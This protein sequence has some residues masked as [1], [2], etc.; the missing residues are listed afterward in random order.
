VTTTTETCTT[1]TRKLCAFKWQLPC[2]AD[3][4]CGDGFVCQPS[5]SGGCGSASRGVSTGPFG[6]GGAASGGSSSSPPAVDAGAPEC[7]T[8]PSFPGWC[9]T[10]ATTCTAD[11]ECPS[12]W[13]CTAIGTPTPLTG[14]GAS[15]SVRGDA[16]AASP[17]DSVDAGGSSTKI[18]IGPFGVG[19]PTRGT[20]DVGTGGE[21]TNTG[22]QGSG[23]TTPPAS[24]GS[25]ATGGTTGGANASS[26]P[27]DGG[28]AVAP[29]RAG[30]SAFLLFGLA[31]VGLGLIR[32]RSRK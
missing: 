13:T 29:P 20:V 8:V 22:H 2:N 9:R 5:V 15:T 7:Q 1:T 26:H 31:A 3:I 21:T 30:D 18:C 14:I 28:C 17:T 27:S 19:A 25:S 16:S 12:G 6:A 23:G 32:R 10:K 4:D 11:T 24:T